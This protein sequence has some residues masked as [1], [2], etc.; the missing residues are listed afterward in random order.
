MKPNDLRDRLFLVLSMLIFATIGIARRYLPIPSGMLAML[1]GAIGAAVLVALLFAFGKRLDLRA[2]RKPLWRLI[3]GGVLIGLNWI[4]L[5]ESYRYTTVAVATLCYYTAPV[6]VLLLSPL[7]LG[8]RL[9]RR[10][11]V[12]ILLALVGIVFVSGVL[13]G[14]GLGG[15]DAL[16]V[17][18]GLLA[19]VLYASV[20]LLNKTVTGVGAPERTV[21]ELLSAAVLL[22]P[23]T[24]VFEDLSAIELTLPICL[25]ILL[26]GVL[27][28]GIAYALYF[29]TIGTLPAATVSVLSYLDPV[30]A[31]LLSALF[32]HEPLTPSVIVG[33]VLILGGTLISELPARRKKD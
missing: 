7:V 14:D 18:F 2:I 4:F 1:R 8:D 25:I 19:A 15:R 5:F 30:G 11:V 33:T 22:L 6:I 23:Y 10:G 21:V 17:L 9:T 31:I 27:H 28:T 16:G 12:S 3:L 13:T 26:V 24:L 20:I 32:L 29:G